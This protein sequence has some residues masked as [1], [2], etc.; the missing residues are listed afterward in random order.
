MNSRVAIPPTRNGIRHPH[1]TN[2]DS[3]W[4]GAELATVLGI[5]NLDSFRVRL[6]QWSH[7]GYIR[8]IGPAHGPVLTS[9]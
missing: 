3:A 8:K 2:A 6:S 5:D 7:Q 9:A 4:K 1:W